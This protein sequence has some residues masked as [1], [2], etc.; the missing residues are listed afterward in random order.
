MYAA[1]WPTFESYPPLK[2]LT[3]K[4][5][6]DVNSNIVRTTKTQKYTVPL[7]RA[8]TQPKLRQTKVMV[9][10]LH[11]F[12]L[13]FSIFLFNSLQALLSSFSNRS[14]SGTSP[15]KSIIGTGNICNIS[16][17]PPPPPHPPPP[18][19]PTC[20]PYSPLL[21]Q[22]SQ[23]GHTEGKKN[24]LCSQDLRWTDSGLADE[25]LWHTYM[26][27][28]NLGHFPVTYCIS[29]TSTTTQTVTWQIHVT[30]CNL[31]MWQYYVNRQLWL[32]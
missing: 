6:K 20:Y 22:L 3:I 7:G 1:T 12:F 4:Y 31:F 32:K 2:A 30:D 5:Q 10:N 26:F 24:P 23:Q 14:V 25:R 21:I 27:G 19:P 9:R 16:L 18:L 8:G 29:V 13:L 11:L 15:F 17:R 28:Q